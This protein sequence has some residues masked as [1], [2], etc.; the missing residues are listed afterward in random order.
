MLNIFKSNK[1]KSVKT[2]DKKKAYDTFID[3]VDTLTQARLRGIEMSLALYKMRMQDHGFILTET[4]CNSSVVNIKR[5]QLGFYVD[6]SKSLNSREDYINYQNGL[7]FFVKYKEEFKRINELLKD[8]ELIMDGYYNANQS[9][10]FELT[11]I[12]KILGYGKERQEEIYEEY[13][14]HPSKEY[15][16]IV[17]LLDL[18]NK[19]NDNESVIEKVLEIITPYFNPDY[20]L[21]IKRVEDKYEMD[22]D[23]TFGIMIKNNVIGDMHMIY[24]V[25]GFNIKRDVYDKFLI[26]KCPYLEVYFKIITKCLKNEMEYKNTNL[27]KKFIVKR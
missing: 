25:D 14:E 16:T 1:V 23:D 3:K 13:P 19:N 20:E 8:K 21:E 6:E 17:K 26:E 11:R 5:N 2:V 15:K 27:N 4:N 7:R 9:D 18:A 10:E 24:A 12:S 22:F